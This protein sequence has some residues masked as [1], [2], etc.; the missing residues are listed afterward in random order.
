MADLTTDEVLEQLQPIFEA[1][2]EAPGIKLT[3]ESSAKNIANWDSIAHIEIVEMVEI[4]FK[5][6]FAL[7]ELQNLKN[8]GD[9]VELVIRKKR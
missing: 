4:R 5:I 2:L 6:R 1:A 9:L 8:V 7:G 3:L